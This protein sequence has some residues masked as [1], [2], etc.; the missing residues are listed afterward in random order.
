MGS[1]R[2][3]ARGRCYLRRTE[4]TSLGSETLP[5]SC[6]YENLSYNHKSDKE[7]PLCACDPA[8][9]G[10]GGKE[11]TPFINLTG[12]IQEQ[13]KGIYKILMGD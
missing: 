2:V 4:V 9:V 11:N 3:E 1:Q 12:N 8:G 13:Y 10:V 5:G 6:R 7:I